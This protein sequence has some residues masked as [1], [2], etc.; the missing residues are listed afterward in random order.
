[1]TL[2]I[3]GSNAYGGPP[4]LLWSG[5]EY[6]AFWK[7]LTPEEVER[8]FFARLSPSGAERERTMLISDAG[9]ELHGFTAEW[10]G[11]E[12][13]ILWCQGEHLDRKLY[14]QR[15]TPDGELYGN[16]IHIPT[17]PSSSLGRLHLVWNGHEY[18]VSWLEQI[19][20]HEDD[21]CRIKVYFARVGFCD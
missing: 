10:T 19:C 6:A 11:S 20:E 13:G 16:R 21:D 17:S 15:M 9:M 3:T 2:S 12:Y 7:D 1:V 8:L 5:T 4:V 18:G 14:I